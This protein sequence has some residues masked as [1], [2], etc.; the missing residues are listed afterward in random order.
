MRDKQ[1]V[2]NEQFTMATEI[3]T[4]ADAALEE[5][6]ELMHAAK[7]ILEKYASLFIP[8]MNQLSASVIVMR[9]QMIKELEADGFT[10]D[11]AIKVVIGR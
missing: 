3:L 2:F 4:A 7:H 5:N 10:R 1:E 8:M 9:K 11:Q 6:P